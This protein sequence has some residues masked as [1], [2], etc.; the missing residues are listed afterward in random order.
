ML[1][2]PGLREQGQSGFKK[3]RIVIEPD[4]R[5]KYSKEIEQPANLVPLWGPIGIFG[6]APTTTAEHPQSLQYLK[7]FATTSSGLMGCSTK[8]IAKTKGEDL[9]N[10]DSQEP[11]LASRAL[12]Q[13]ADDLSVLRGAVT[14]SNMRFSFSPTR[15]ILVH[16]ELAIVRHD[17]KNIIVFQVRVHDCVR[18]RRPLHFQVMV[19]AGRRS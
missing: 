15:A 19:L 7:R 14:D 6:W 10:F 4:H 12:M 16:H 11:G 2:A 5:L 13:V 8:R 3:K 18:G 17:C 1:K 9:T